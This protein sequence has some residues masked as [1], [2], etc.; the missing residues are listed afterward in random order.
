MKR[1]KGGGGNIERREGER[2][3]KI[4]MDNS[5]KCL[6]PTCLISFSPLCVLDGA[7]H[8]TQHPLLPSVGVSVRA[9]VS[10]LKLMLSMTI[11]VIK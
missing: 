10:H 9:S 11:I 6:L 1:E 7:K 3:I 2:K 4:A 8:V 5:I